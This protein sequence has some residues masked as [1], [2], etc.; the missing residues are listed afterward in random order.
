MLFEAIAFMIAFP[1][2]LLMAKWILYADFEVNEY[3]MMKLFAM[4]WDGNPAHERD[5][6]LAVLQRLHE[7]KAHKKEI[8]YVKER[9][10]LTKNEDLGSKNSERKVLTTL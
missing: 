9:L 7:K 2:C 1:L 4:F 8:L 5:A 3:R 6:W 10:L